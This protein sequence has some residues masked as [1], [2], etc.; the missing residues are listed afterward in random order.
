MGISDFIGEE[1]I[2]GIDRGDENEFFWMRFA[3]KYWV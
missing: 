3:I 1:E 2:G